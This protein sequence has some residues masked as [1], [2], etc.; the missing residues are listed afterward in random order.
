[1]LYFPWYNE[2]SDLLGGCPTYEEHY[3]NVVSVVVA[4]EQ[5]FTISNVEDSEV[6]VEN[7]PQ[8]MWDQ[9]A[10]STEGSRVR[11]Q[12]DSEEPLTNTD[13]Q[14]LTENSRILER[15]NAII[16]RYESAANM[17]EIPPD[18]Y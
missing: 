11:S 2:Q 14:D 7:R 1:M 5:K 8:H 16:G 3:H 6:D 10:P 15:G 9:L 17:K 13:Q 4:N 18:E 12:E